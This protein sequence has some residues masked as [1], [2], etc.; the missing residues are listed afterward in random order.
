MVRAAMRRARGNK[1]EA[2]RILGIS[3][4]SMLQKIKLYGAGVEADD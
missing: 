4:P 1:S 2:A 3:Y